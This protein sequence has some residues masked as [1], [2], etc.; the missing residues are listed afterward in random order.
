MRLR[1]LLDTNICIYIAKNRPDEVLKR[2]QQLGVGEVAMSV[3]THG[4]LCF[5]ACKSRRR[6]EAQKA[7]REMATMIPVLPLTSKVGERYG[8]IRSELEKSGRPIGNN[9]IWIAAHALALG[10]VL[11]TNNAREFARIP[12]LAVENWVEGAEQSQ[13]HEAKRRY[14]TRR[15]LRR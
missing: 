8:E 7:L 11:V 2:F 3:I 6:E 15:N 1:Y 12:D 10:V 9:D 4:E 14:R 5:G 13:V